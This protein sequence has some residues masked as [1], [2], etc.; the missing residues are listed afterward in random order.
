[1]TKPRAGV[2]DI[3][4]HAGADYRQHMASRLDAGRLKVMGAIEACRT[5]VLGGHMYRCDGCGRDHPLYNSCRNRH[6]PTCQGLAARQWMEA[7]AADILPVPYF[8]VVFTLP[9]EVAQITFSNRSVMV[10][11]LFRT[12]TETLCTIAADPRH[13]GL[14][15]GGT[16]VLHTWD[17]R[18]QFHPH[19]HVVIP[20]AGFEVTTGQWKTGRSTFLAP[21]KVLA[22]LFR[23]RFLEELEHAHARGQIE[24]HG[25][26]AHLAN[27]A[28][29]RA[30]LKIARGKDWVVY[31]KP[32]F[33]NAEQV[34]GYLSRYT[35][36]I[37]I[38]NS[39]ILKFDGTNVS[40]RCRKPVRP[41]QTRPRYGVATVT[42]REFIRRFLL[43]VL[44]DGMHRIRHFGILANG[45]RA[46][47]LQSAREALSVDDRFQPNP[48]ECDNA[49]EEAPND[50]PED[51]SAPVVCPHC[52]GEL[53]KIAPILPRREGF[54]SRDP[55]VTSPPMDPTP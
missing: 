16:S 6:C 43:H 35:H 20:N 3:F 23:R 5:S 33:R 17:Q 13:G 28:S 49:Q 26:I 22:S 50:N 18:L 31:A 9:K 11:I 47:T 45:C 34:F 19:L 38:G 42:A 27:P 41:G 21:V 12:V 29:F 30:N 24:C 51:T 8:H 4:R 1:M 7:R 53:R 36:R 25:A 2:A 40:F 55:P 52:G 15:V 10:N 32:P 14:R 48:A 39:R 54:S 46:K 37:A 44:P